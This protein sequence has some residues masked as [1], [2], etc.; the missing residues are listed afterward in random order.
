MLNEESG[1]I[2]NLGKNNYFTFYLEK[3]HINEY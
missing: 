1:D 3:E 2:F